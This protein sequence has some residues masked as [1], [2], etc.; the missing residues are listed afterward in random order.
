MKKSNQTDFYDA[1]DNV[2][3]LAAQLHKMQKEL[4][5]KKKARELHAGRIWQA[6]DGRWATYFNDGPGGKRRLVKR[7]SEYDLCKAV[8]NLYETGQAVPAVPTVEDCCR[9]F[10][11]KKLDNKKMY[12]K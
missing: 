1:E 5:I 3:M 10:N 6:S 12:M 2:K 7:K 4:E 11:K 9:A 8:C